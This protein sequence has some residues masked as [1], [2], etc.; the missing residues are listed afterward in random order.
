MLQVQA[1]LNGSKKAIKAAV[2]DLRASDEAKGRA[3]LSVLDKYESCLGKIEVAAS[4]PPPQ[5]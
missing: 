5:D 2:D 3:G 1:P 4:T